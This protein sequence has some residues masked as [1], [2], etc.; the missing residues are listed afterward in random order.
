MIKRKSLLRRSPQL[1]PVICVCC[2][3]SLWKT[4]SNASEFIS[5]NEKDHLSFQTAALQNT[6]E[7]TRVLLFTQSTLLKEKGNNLQKVPDENGTL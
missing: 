7:I 3:V 5:F 1:R 4:A 2:R 6:A